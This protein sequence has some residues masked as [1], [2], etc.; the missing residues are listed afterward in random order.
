M[1]MRKTILVVLGGML[2][3]TGVHA[4]QANAQRVRHGARDGA[5]FLSVG[6]QQL[7]LGE[8]NPRLAAAGYP[9]FDESRL[10]VGGGAYIY[11]DRVV[12]GAEGHAVVGPGE[13]TADGIHRTRLTGGVGTVHLG[14]SIVHTPRVRIHPMIGLGGAGATLDIVDRTAPSFDDVLARPG[15]NARLVSGALMLDASLGSTVRLTDSARPRGGR[16]GIVL[17]VRAG[18]GFAPFAGE[19]R[20]ENGNHVAGGPEVTL[21][22]PYIRAMVGGWGVGRRRR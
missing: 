10:S 20:M 5:A 12:L 9:T 17:G 1:M 11:R 13:T 18:Y 3:A 16:G 15:R 21:A 4:D 14:Y 22:G 6:W 2:V 8:L 19:W 7:D